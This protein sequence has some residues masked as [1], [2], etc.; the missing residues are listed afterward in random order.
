MINREDYATF[1]A[2]REAHTASHQSPERLRQLLEARNY[3]LVFAS[4]GRFRI[5]DVPPGTYELRI[6]VTKP[7]GRGQ[8]WHFE[9]SEDELGSLIKEVVVPPGEGTFDL[10]TIKVPMKS[11][12]ASPNG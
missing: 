11:V 9:R 8:R 5:D 7:L 1:K 4:E 2:F 6:K 10:A 12:D 3:E